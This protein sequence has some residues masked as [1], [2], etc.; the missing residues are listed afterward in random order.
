MVILTTIFINLFKCRTALTD[1]FAGFA[2]PLPLQP[3]EMWLFLFFYRYLASMFC[4]VQSLRN[5]CTWRS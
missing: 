5:L 3:S 2:P 1:E 4:A